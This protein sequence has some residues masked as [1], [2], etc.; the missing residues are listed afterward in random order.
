MRRL[1]GVG[2]IASS[3]AN[4]SASP[5]RERLGSGGGASG[6]SARTLEHEWRHCRDGLR[7][8]CGHLAVQQSRQAVPVV[9]HRR[10]TPGVQQADLFERPG[11]A[12]ELTR[13]AG[14][15][16]VL[17]GVGPASRV[18]N[19]VIHGCGHGEEGA[20][21][22]S[23]LAPR[24]GA[25]KSCAQCADRTFGGTTRQPQNRHRQPSR[26]NRALVASA[27][28]M[29]AATFVGNRATGA[30]GRLRWM[31]RSPPF[32]TRAACP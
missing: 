12:A 20:M 10:A 1:E 16:H 11:A 22:A 6:M 14:G 21:E 24:Y 13:P 5:R 7:G 3:A 25:G 32:M 2:W 19:D 4:Q 15:D 29:R 23:G 26:A 27:E 17:L 8:S 18:R 31:L 9:Q 28:G 30:T